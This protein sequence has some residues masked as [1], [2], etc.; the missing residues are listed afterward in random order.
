MGYKVII[1]GTTGMDHAMINALDGKYKKTIFE[2]K[3]INEFVKQ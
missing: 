1:T 3:D 2:N